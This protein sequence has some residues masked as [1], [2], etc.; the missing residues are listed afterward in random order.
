MKTNKKIKLNFWADGDLQK[1]IKKEAKK[2][3]RNISN[4]IRSKLKKIRGVEE[5]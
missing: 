1:A 2:E 3:N 5:W 4:F